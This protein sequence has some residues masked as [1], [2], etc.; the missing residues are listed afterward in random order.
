MNLHWSKLYFQD[1]CTEYQHAEAL[2]LVVCQGVACGARDSS[3]EGQTVP[4]VLQWNLVF[5][6]MLS[7]MDILSSALLESCASGSFIRL[8]TSD[9]NLTHRFLLRGYFFKI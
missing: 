7:A 2:W 8:Q 5:S 3:E 6:S 1:P 9:S 4:L